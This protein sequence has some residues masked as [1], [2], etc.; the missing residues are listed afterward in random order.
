MKEEVN[1]AGI[2]ILCISDLHLGASDT[3]G[4][5]GKAPNETTQHNLEKDKL[6][7]LMKT[8]KKI[9]TN[10]KIDFIFFSGDYLTG[11]DS[12]EEK[13]KATKQFKKFLEEIERSSEI[14]TNSDHIVQRIVIVPGNHDM[15]R[16]DDVMGKEID[17]LE[18]FKNTFEKYLHP[19][20]IRSGKVAQYAPLFVF[21]ELKLA[22][23][24]I[25]T[26]DNAA[27]KNDLIW[28]T[29]DYLKKISPDTLRDNLLK[30]LEDLKFCDIPAVSN[31]TLDTFVQSN[32]DI[33][34]QVK[35][36]DDYRKIFIS[37][38]PLLSGTEK[39]VTIKV[40]PNTIGGYE[41]LDAAS[42]L[43]YSLFIHGHTHEF[44]CLELRDRSIK[45]RPSILQIGI[46][47]FQ[48]DHTDLKIVKLELG[49]DQE[50][51]RIKSLYL[52][53]VTQDF[54]ENRYIIA[55]NDLANARCL[56]EAEGVLV[57]S[58][59]EQIINQGII[60]RNANSAR[61]EAA[62]YDCA[63]GKGYKRAKEQ[64]LFEWTNEILKPSL[65]GPAKIELKP[66]ETVLIYTEEEFD[67][68]ANMILHASPISSWARRGLRVDISYF[69]DPGFRGSFCFPVTNMGTT[70]LEINS[71]DPIMSIE[72]IKLSKAAKTPW[73]KKHPDKAS[74][75]KNYEDK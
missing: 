54:K 24:C 4:L 1:K 10:D 69:V 67:I 62:S 12:Q 61:I 43:G 20:S 58:E 70:S 28:N 26:V 27:T 66:K 31:D 5:Y 46:P 11:W 68:P 19:F 52:D 7:F 14:F 21:E 23:Y 60:I 35:N 40:Y 9:A 18:S 74:E 47:D 39:G 2:R 73:Y 44:S 30:E 17:G 49:E 25:S 53:Y 42:Q 63:L 32:S 6:S 51:I 13:K 59:I 37:H 64:T 56:V 36:F 22:I 16:T 41:L 29:I 57:D 15:A 71:K 65:E 38:H 55:G 3:K 8:L 75:R 34:Q 50:G 45:E 48:F 33:K 72:F